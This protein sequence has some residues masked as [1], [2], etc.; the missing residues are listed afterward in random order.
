MNKIT[1]A[2]V[3]IISAVAAH[4]GALYLVPGVIM[5]RTFD[6]MEGRGIT[7]SAFTLVPRVTPENQTVVRPSPDLAY[8]ICLF[9]F[10]DNQSPLNIHAT[11]WPLQ[12]T[13]Q[14]TGRRE[15]YAS[16]S[17]FDARTNNFATVRVM[18]DGTGSNITLMP[19]NSAGKYNIAVR[20][21]YTL[22]VIEAPTEQGIILIRRLAASD[23]EYAKVQDLAKTDRCGA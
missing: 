19:P 23:S 13:E 7:T 18:A 9:D 22:K 2:L 17:F 14:Q 15:G 10:R 5:N 4:Y 6:A 20:K 21:G 3:F 12:E 1:L 11:P 16:V 8:S